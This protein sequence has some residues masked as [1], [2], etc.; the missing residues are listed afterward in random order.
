M[1]LIPTRCAED[2]DGKAKR[3]VQVLH[4]FGRLVDQDDGAAMPRE[5]TR[6]PFL[7]FPAEASL[8]VLCERDVLE[9]RVGETVKSSGSVTTVSTSLLVNVHRPKTPR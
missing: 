6:R 4:A 3:A 1:Q 8:R 9:R 7:V 5:Q 2:A